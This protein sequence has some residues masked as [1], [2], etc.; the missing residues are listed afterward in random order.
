MQTK[1]WQQIDDLFNSAVDLEA[2]ERLPF[3]RKSCGGDVALLAEVESLLNAY[4][5]RKELMEEPAFELVLKVMS[6]TQA[7]SMVG[8]TVGGYRILE[9]LGKGGMGE[10]YLADDTRLGRKVALKFLSPEFVGDNWAKRQLVKEAHSVAILDHPNICPVYDLEEHEGYSFIVMQ[11]V[12]GK[13]LAEMI[14]DDTLPGDRVLPLARQIVSAIAEAHVHGII[15]R[16]I[17]P[18]N[19]VIT[20]GGQA[21]VLDFGLAKHTHPK[22][23]G[24]DL[25]DSVSHLTQA[26]VMAGTVAY[27]SPEQ[28]RAEKLDFRSDIFSL[29][30]VLY[31]MVEGKRA[32]ARDSQ[33][34]VISAILTSQ[35]APLNPDSLEIPPGLGRIIFKCLEKQKDRRYQSASELLFEL[36]SPPPG[37]ARTR[38]LG[39]RVTIA[40]LLL[41]ILLTTAFFVFR[42][43]Q[44]PIKTLAI[45]PI[46]SVNADPGTEPLARGLTEDLINKVSQISTLRV[47]P[48]TTVS[49]YEGQ[50]FNPIEVGRGLHVDAVVVSTFVRQGEVRVLQIRLLDTSDGSQLWG[51][52]YTLRSDGFLD[53]LEEVA[54]KLVLKLGPLPGGETLPPTRSTQNNAALT[55]YYGGRN[56]WDKRT[57]DNIEQIRGYFE[58][59]ISLDPAFAKPY[60][61]LAD[62][63]MQLNTPAYGS[64]P[65]GE[66]V[67]KAKFLAGR[68]VELD[69]NLPEAHTS[70][71][72]VNLR[73]EWNLPQA[74]AEFSR[75]IA[76][77]P[78]DAWPH[79][80][81]SQLLSI[82]GRF[83]EAINESNVAKELAPFSPVAKLGV[84]RTLYFARR[85]SEAADCAKRIID[86]NPGDKIANYILCYTYLKRGRYG[87]ALEL[88][89]P[90]YE[91]D[92]ALWAAPLGFAYGKRR[93]VAKALMV[94]NDLQQLSKENYSLSQERA[95]V[96]TGLGD[97]D[98]ALEWLEQ[99]Y[100]ERFTTLIFV[101]T[102]PVYDDLWPDPRFG[103]L[104]VRLGLPVR[105]ISARAVPTHWGGGSH[106]DRSVQRRPPSAPV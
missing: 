64:M 15:H 46:S 91:E 56:L 11:Y 72:L 84:C 54:K 98:K 3:L 95:I 62:Y 6:S 12:E 81:N 32:F 67:G 96:Y 51:E 28:L 70:L 100:K 37:P 55:E 52:N 21:K 53:L 76:L 7:A 31:E 34:E 90:R 74:E 47:K 104:V 69:T 94:L 41:L 1:V 36:N 29:G 10:V 30:V 82:K 40:A 50:Q 77:N 8:L 43:R 14:R 26:G 80:W 83:D 86:E 39:L 45:L 87:E 35:P 38:R 58:K 85:Y 16:D 44:A 18:G 57:K 27:M 49:G 103:D 23:T 42:R 75:A 19:I 33:A 97:N 66:V 22:P 68:A 4:E 89:E 99:S 105:P 60:A 88:I 24:L 9:P 71:G 93:E 73:F 106:V 48:F 13:T 78:G 63:Y 65:A 92:K 17:K 25:A 5:N 79:Y 102:E 101:T 2:S 61:G 20:K 59:A